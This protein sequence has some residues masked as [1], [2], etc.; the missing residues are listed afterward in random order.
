M[1]GTITLTAGLGGMG[2]AQ[3][4]AVTLNDGVAICVDC[5]QAR[6][7]RRIEQ[8][9]L[10]VQADDIDDALARAVQA[11]DAKRPLSIGLLDNAAGSSPSCCPRGAH[12]HRDR[13]DLGTRPAELPARRRRV[14]RHEEAGR[15]GPGV[16]H[17]AGPA[18]VARHVAAMVGFMDNGAE[19]FDYGNS[20]R[21]EAKKRA[22][23]HAL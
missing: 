23:S 8:R 16:L 5:D 6:I 11:R 18:S 19:V 22:A 2:G 10:D 3:P 17:R 4:L 9:Y 7:T 21:D 13:S 1:A 14:R 12:R 20:I 15:E